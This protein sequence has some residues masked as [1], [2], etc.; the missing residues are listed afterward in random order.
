MPK[1]IYYLDLMPIMTIFR[2][3]D[4]KLVIV[5]CKSIYTLFEPDV[6]KNQNF[7]KHRCAPNPST[8]FHFG[9]WIRIRYLTDTSSNRRLSLYHHLPPSPL[10]SRCLQTSQASLFG[11]GN[12]IREQKCRLC[13]HVYLSN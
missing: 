3:N 1:S 6:P 2:E 4:L 10:F 7:T 8:G 12:N 5:I 13:K 9:V 11:K